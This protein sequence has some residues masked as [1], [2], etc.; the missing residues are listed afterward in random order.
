MRPDRGT[1]TVIC[2]T[3]VAVLA[4][5]ACILYFMNEALSSQRVVARQKLAEAYR[6]Q[7]RSLQQKLDGA[8][9]KR[10]AD[11]DSLTGSPAAIFSKTVAAHLADAVIYLDGAGRPVYPSLPESPASDPR[12]GRPDWETAVA[13]ERAGRFQEAAAAFRR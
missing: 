12:A 8:W 4:P 2:L 9:Q 10:T 11:L 6:G 3:L 1:W 7:L 5:T 13:L